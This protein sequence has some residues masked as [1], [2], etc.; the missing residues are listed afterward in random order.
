MVHR[1]G[2]AGCSRINKP[3][4]TINSIVFPVSACRGTLASYHN[5][6]KFYVD[7]FI[8]YLLFPELEL[9]THKHQNLIPSRTP[10]PLSLLLL[11]LI[12]IKSGKKNEK[13]R[14]HK[15]NLPHTTA[16]NILSHVCSFQSRNVFVSFKESREK[17]K[18]SEVSK[19]NFINSLEDSRVKFQIP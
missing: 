14:K 7:L 3:M 13:R 8:L 6:T 5:T 10:H 9:L 16:K 12:V 15:Q 2:L 1:L 11:V 18:Y 4:A 19:A 17:L